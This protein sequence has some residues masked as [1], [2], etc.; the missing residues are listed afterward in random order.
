MRRPV[1]LAATIHTGPVSTAPQLERFGSSWSFLPPSP[2]FSSV[3]R[4]GTSCSRWCSR[5]SAS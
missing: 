5:R 1:W 2:R 4:S 3:S